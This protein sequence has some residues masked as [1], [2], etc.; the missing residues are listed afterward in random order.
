MDKYYRVPKPADTQAEPNEIKLSFTRRL[1]ASIAKGL[2]LL[3]KKQEQVIFIKALGSKMIAKA[4]FVAE[5]LKHRV[6][7][8]HQITE[9]GTTGVVTEYLPKEEGLDKVELVK[10]TAFIKITLSASPLDTSNPGYQ[11]PIPDSLVRPRGPPGSRG[12]RGGGRGR[13]RGRGGFR[14]G[15]GRGGFRGGRGRGGRG[16]FRAGRG[17]NPNGDHESTQ[18][19]GGDLKPATTTTTTTEGGPIEGS[20]FRGGRGGFRGRGRGRGGFRGGRG[21]G[22]FRGGRG[23]RGRG[24]FRGGRGGRGGPF[25]PTGAATSPSATTTTTSP[26]TEGVVE[27]SSGPEKRRQTARRGG[28]GGGSPKSTSPT[29]TSP[30]TN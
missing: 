11:A 16:G 6:V 17:P 12:G 24:G 8:L 7:G 25:S 14:G 10:Q 1:R 26:T 28:R 29:T 15:R 13:G 2:N 19:E 9:I 27:S 21:R 3:E 20:G 5:I 22:G 30:T 4:I 18:E 23:G